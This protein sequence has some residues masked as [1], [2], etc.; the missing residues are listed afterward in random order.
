MGEG[1]LNHRVGLLCT[2]Y[3]HARK[4]TIKCQGLPGLIAL[5]T[6]KK[7][8]KPRFHHFRTEVR[9]EWR[10]CERMVV[11]EEHRKVCREGQLY[12]E[13]V[14][15]VQSARQISGEIKTLTEILQTFIEKFK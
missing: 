4:G 15:Q 7:L 5:I 1:L 10:Y 14:Q 6:D 2:L 13:T 12:A 8:P 9:Q 11:P 3:Y